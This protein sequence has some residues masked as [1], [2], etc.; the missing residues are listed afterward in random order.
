MLHQLS[1]L[2]L[3]STA[4]AV[5]A[6]AGV[7][8]WN[9]RAGFSDYLR[10]QDGQMLDRLMLLAEQDLAQRRQVPGLWP[11]RPEQWRP[12][13]RQWLDGSLDL[14][15]GRRAGGGFDEPD[16]GRPPPRRPPL[17]GGW[18]DRPPPPPPPPRPNG[19]PNL[20]GPRLVLLDASGTRA[21]AGHREVIDLPGQLRALKVEGDTVLMLRLAERAGPAQGVDASFLRRQ[22]WGLGGMAVLLIALALLAARL[23][24]ARWVRPLQAAQAATRRIAHGELTVRIAKQRDDELGELSEDINAMAAALARLESSRRRWIAELSHELRTP[25]AVLR[26]ELEALQDGIRP[27]DAAALP[28]L[29]DEVQRLSRLTDDFHTLAMSELQELPCSFAPT[30]VP[31]LLSEALARIRS[32]AVAAGLTLQSDWPQAL[33]QALWDGE[34]IAQMMAN[35]LENSLRYTDAP[36]LVRLS[37]RLLGEHIEV[38]LEDSKPGVPA[39]ALAHLFEPLYRVDASRSRQAGGSGLGLG[40]AQAIARSHGGHLQAEPSSLGGLTLRLTLPLRPPAAKGTA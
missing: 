34:R 36:G 2:L 3:A 14:S 28:S 1:L 7:V 39:A 13:L 29:Q 20:F 16:A 33:P 22:Y 30:D 35:L 40:V 5:L 19:D 8:A 26:A 38:S 11:E 17:L 18:R 37:A 24:A 10:A 9:L 21:L 6:M 31:A 25:L 12:V 15:D 23:L 32:R 27:L 4:L